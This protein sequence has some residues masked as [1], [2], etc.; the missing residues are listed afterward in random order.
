[1]IEPIKVALKFIAS[2]ALATVHVSQMVA[3]F[4]ALIAA[5]MAVTVAAAI[6]PRG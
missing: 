2:R 1:M 3:I 6:D 5:M 4:G